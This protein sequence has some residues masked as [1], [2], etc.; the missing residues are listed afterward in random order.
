MVP[1]RWDIHIVQISTF[2]EKM[3]SSIR[4]LRIECHCSFRTMPGKSDV[5]VVGQ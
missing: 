3:V 1:H 5:A 2:L 4:I